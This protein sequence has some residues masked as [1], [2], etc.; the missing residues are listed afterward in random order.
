MA[1][2]EGL[3]CEICLRADE[4]EWML[5]VKIP[6]AAHN[7]HRFAEL[8]RDCAKAIAGSWRATQGEPAAVESK[9]AP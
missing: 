3:S 6:H 7:P 8:C 4:P 2:S 5:Q 1:S 9:D